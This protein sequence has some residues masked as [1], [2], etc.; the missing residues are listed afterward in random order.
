MLKIVHNNKNLKI[1]NQLK[2]GGFMPTAVPMIA[3]GVSL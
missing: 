2:K 1:W 3:A